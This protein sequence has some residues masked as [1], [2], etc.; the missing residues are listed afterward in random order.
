MDVKYKK[1][2]IIKL[3]EEKLLYVNFTG[4]NR[5]SETELTNRAIAM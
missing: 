4:R 2:T 1:Y 5:C 3:T